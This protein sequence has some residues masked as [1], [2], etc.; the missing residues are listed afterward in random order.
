MQYC[1]QV[2]HLHA[3]VA[4]DMPIGAF[5]SAISP[6]A[7]GFQSRDQLYA[8]VEFAV[9]IAGPLNGAAGAIRVKVPVHANPDWLPVMKHRFAAMIGG[10]VQ[11]R[12]LDFRTVD[13][14]SIS[15]VPVE[16]LHRVGKLHVFAGDKELRLP[17]VPAIPIEY[18]VT[19]MRDIDRWITDTVEDK[20]PALVARYLAP[21]KNAE[22][23]QAAV[24]G[25]GPLVK[26]IEGAIQGADRVAWAEFVRTRHVNAPVV[27]PAEE[28]NRAAHAIASDV[29]L[30]EVRR[31]VEAAAPQIKQHFHQV[32]SA[33]IAKELTGR[34]NPD[35]YAPIAGLS[36]AAPSTQGDA[37]ENIH[38]FYR[39]LAEDI[40]TTPHVRE[41]IS[42]VLY[43]RP[44]TAIGCR[45]HENQEP[46][47]A[48]GAGTVPSSTTPASAVTTPSTIRTFAGIQTRITYDGA[49]DVSRVEGLRR[50]LATVLGVNPRDVSVMDQHQGS[51]VIDYFITVDQSILTATVQKINTLPTSVTGVLKIQLFDSGPSVTSSKA[52]PPYVPTSPSGAGGNPEDALRNVK[53]WAELQTWLSTNLGNVLFANEKDDAANRKAYDKLAL[54]VPSI[55]SEFKDEE[56][57]GL[58]YSLY[59]MFPASEKNGYDIKQDSW[60]TWDW[61]DV[62]LYGIASRFRVSQ[63]RDQYATFEDAVNTSID[64][65]VIVDLMNKNNVVGD[66]A[67]QIR[68]FILRMPTTNRDLDKMK[69]IAARFP[70]NVKTKVAD[71][72]GRLLRGTSNKDWVKTII[73]RKMA[74]DAGM[75]IADL[76][77]AEA[78]SSSAV[79]VMALAM[80][81]HLAG[82]KISDLYASPT[83]LK[84]I[85]QGLRI[86]PSMMVSPTVQVIEQAIQNKIDTVQ[87]NASAA[88]KTA[89][90]AAALTQQQI[91]DAKENTIALTNAADLI[92][93][94]MDTASERA[95]IA[96]DRAVQVGS[97]ISDLATAAAV[98]VAATKFQQVSVLRSE[99]AKVL[100]SAV[101]KLTQAR[102]ASD[103]AGIQSANADADKDIQTADKYYADVN[104]LANEIEAAANNAEA[105]AAAA[106]AAASQPQPVVN[107]QG[108]EYK[109]Q[110]SIVAAY[111]TATSDIAVWK[112]L[113]ERIRK[114]LV[115]TD[116]QKL[117]EAISIQYYTYKRVT[118][119]FNWFEIVTS[120]AQ[121]DPEIRGNKTISEFK[122]T[123]KT[124]L[125]M[126]VKGITFGDVENTLTQIVNDD[127]TFD[128]IDV[129]IDPHHP[130]N[131]MIHH[132]AQPAMGGA[133]PAYYNAMHT[134]QDMTAQAPYMGN[135]ADTYRSYHLFGGVPIAPL[136]GLE[137]IGYHIG[138]HQ[139]RC[140]KTSRAFEE[141]HEKA[142]TADL[143]DRDTHGDSKNFRSQVRGFSDMN[144]EL[145]P[146]VPL[147]R[148]PTS[149]APPVLPIGSKAQD[150]LLINC[151]ADNSSGD[152]SDKKSPRPSMKSMYGSN[153]NSE[154]PPLVP[155]KRAPVSKA[156]P[157]VPIG[158]ELPPLVPLVRA[159]ISK[160]PPVVPI[161]SEAQAMLPIDNNLSDDDDIEA[162]ISSAN[163]AQMLLGSM[164][165]SDSDSDVDINDQYPAAPI[166]AS[167]ASR[168]IPP[169]PPTIALIEAEEDDNPFG[170]PTLK[171]AL[172]KKK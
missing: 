115:T 45:W 29:L 24:R 5:V 2:E 76:L 37:I 163:R 67:T 167:V 86:D 38:E 143:L 154:L 53:T 145:P 88:A 147:V 57:T 116:E 157:V 3:Q 60:T 146:L 32:E 165:D 98:N 90:Q 23:L 168:V 113:L 8:P 59:E 16:Q 130:W 162:D 82:K 136:G 91:Q 85:L 148:A 102:N 78:K 27:M 132:S 31:M 131:A 83:Q 106:A 144:S 19:K 65:H 134:K 118:P 68:E 125:N 140:E 126:N 9:Q 122:I 112:I 120:G 63:R 42:A 121:K 50:A 75:K 79:D 138:S 127:T 123:I 151:H 47:V 35:H 97:G 66:E 152:E 15:T 109:V 129:S 30:G 21:C 166:R 61:V 36:A 52:F 93:S 4:P 105:A 44:M 96:N 33:R 160:A 139:K 12:T 92:I 104:I 14:R 133:Y 56:D 11:A 81:T 28:A 124:M 26:A 153:V 62:Y 25:D 46:I 158:D 119:P 156:P 20:L 71:P 72:S 141:I 22:E 7:L 77:V 89:A 164:F 6:Q 110:K 84:T 172:S 39:D 87:S 111:E 34:Q 94:G 101:D 43:T 170:M 155:L 117:T 64:Y 100:Q 142:R 128:L 58:V 114:G 103:L 69:S 41:A 40:V 149:K 107:V 13:G 99:F 150:M 54:L 51:L 137:R 159:P 80:H 17:Q 55:R 48:G 49:Y 135:A 70:D 108:K 74:V 161:G 95:T 171:Q 169:C 1:P 73:K 18:S 10:S